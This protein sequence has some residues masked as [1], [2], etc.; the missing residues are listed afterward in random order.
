MGFPLK[1]NLSAL[2]MLISLLRSSN[3]TERGFSSFVIACK[4]FI[5]ALKSPFAF[6]AIFVKTSLSINPSIYLAQEKKLLLL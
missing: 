6:T 5:A 4:S 2:K 3:S 1:T